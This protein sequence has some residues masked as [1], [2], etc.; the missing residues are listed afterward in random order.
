MTKR[1][2]SRIPFY[3]LI[4]RILFLV[5]HLLI[6]L[7]LL[8]TLP[9][10]GQPY[11]PGQISQVLAANEKLTDDAVALSTLPIWREALTLSE[12]LEELRT[13]TAK[14]QAQ[15]SA[16]DTVLGSELPIFESL[17]ATAS[18]AE[19]EARLV[20]ITAGIEATQDSL[21][22]LDHES[23]VT[24]E[25]IVELPAL[26]AKSRDQLVDLGVPVEKADTLGLAEYQRAL[27]GREVIEARVD[28]HQ[29]ELA[30][31]Q[32]ESEQLPERI[33]LR[34][35]H[36]AQ[37][38]GEKEQLEGLITSLRKEELQT[39][40]EALE[41]AVR[42][43]SAIPELEEVLVEIQDYNERRIGKDGL[44]A[45][46]REAERYEKSINRISQRIDSQDRNARQKIK[47]LESVE[48]GIDAETSIVLRQQRAHLPRVSELSRML[49]ANIQRV[50]QSQIATLDLQEELD[51][52]SPLESADIFR[53]IEEVPDLS[54]E[55]LIAL[56]EQR[57]ELMLALAHDH[58]VLNR[59]LAETNEQVRLTIDKIEAFSHFLDRR[60]LWIK[61]TEPIS[62]SEPQEEWQRV[63]AL[64]HPEVFKQ[65]GESVRL[66]WNKRLVPCLFLCTVFLFT[67]L[68]RR[69][70][71][72]YLKE[73]SEQ[74]VQRNCRSIAPT[75]RTILISVL[76]AFMLPALFFLL[77]A[78]ISE[79][80][81]YRTGLLN[82]G[83][84][85][86]VSGLIA[87]FSRENGLFD[88]HFKFS[89]EKLVKIRS[90]LRYFIPILVPLVF[91]VGAL[92]SVGSNGA[93]GRVVFILA[94][95]GVMVL[96]HF[97]FYPSRSLVV[98]GK[99]RLFKKL[100]YLF[101]VGVP[102][103]FSIGSALG[104]F[105]SVLTLRTQ[106][107]A[108][109]GVLLA[110]FLVI[111]FFNR[112][113]LVSRRSLAV[114]QALERR[115]AELVERRR[116][117]GCEDEWGTQMPNLEEVEARALDVVEVEAQTTQL[118]RLSVY[119]SA[120]FAI[121][122]IW[123]SSLT[124]LS[125]LDQIPLWPVGGSA[126]ETVSDSTSQVMNL[127]YDQSA[128]PAENMEEAASTVEE[129]VSPVQ[130][131][132][133]VQDLLLSILLLML[134]FVAA[135][136]VPNLLS[137]TLFN[138]LNLGPG[139]N[140]AFTTIVRYAIVMTGV[141]IGLGKVGITWDKV[142]WLAAAISLGIGFGLQEIFANFVAGL[143]L[144]FERPIRI[145]DVVTV[146]DVS[147]KVTEI[148]IRATTIQKFNNRALVVPNK[149]FITSKL[150]N[151]T[152]RD[153]VL[154]FELTVGI[155]YG[156][157]TRKATEILT[158]IL[159]D[160]PHVLSD[161]APAV[162]FQN[163][164]ASSLDFLMRA[165]VGRVEVLVDTQSE[166]HYQ[167]DDA[168]REA[169]IEIAF[170]QQ[171]IHLRSVPEGFHLAQSSTEE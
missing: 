149:D 155:A 108:S 46:I 98:G 45:Q 129:I 19:Q 163:F 164:G 119:F 88:S 59:S 89:G 57:R 22:L 169:G 27:L 87:E 61:S 11:R 60:L 18:L 81:A 39:A 131:R 115:E 54:E 143:I 58:Q 102:L 114:S 93:S 66:N 50:A 32:F 65:V 127:T 116:E 35:K 161:P 4:R 44:Q 126:A 80:V 77:V 160:H 153:T 104:F 13:Q 40:N 15:V 17:S 159:A 140:F 132:V 84:L 111:R 2:N 130:D 29:S 5:K 78:L 146:G 82:A 134:T 103:V 56:R 47:L 106:L 117:E 42:K 38:V 86:F 12:E 25:R 64:F 97:L 90:L 136:N 157:D 141:V 85:L 138:R 1:T 67:L 165:H 55:E 110:A 171:D 154:R 112:W 162:I 49:R 122:A 151:W 30:F 152:L 123:S 128:T 83:L 9:L 139:G 34:K 37:L 135:R 75:L 8:V 144:L 26:I 107:L 41:E 91:A 100:C 73:A 158:K 10:L 62:L 68:R 28:L 168:F 52:P 16:P 43:F 101:A 51:A 71:K 145:G 92:S 20:E 6:F 113:I 31:R 23:A 150:I 142:Q 63:R 148:K 69:Q 74:A 96:A 147:G 21:T 99:G 121:W 24:V 79:P 105:V 53:L 124:A 120:F 72:Q 94:M 133:T 3:C 14:Y 36:L 137:L 170:P 48:L 70:L 76:L 167:I 156:S 118:V 33:E 95:M 7:L 109:V 125:V 166:I